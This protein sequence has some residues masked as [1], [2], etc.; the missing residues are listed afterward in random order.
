MENKVKR[1]VIMADGTQISAEELELD[2]VEAGPA[3]ED[4]EAGLR[5]GK[6]QRRNQRTRGGADGRALAGVTRDRADG[7]AAQGSP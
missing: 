7:Q 5:S 2:D 1:A 6:Q 4:H 3:D